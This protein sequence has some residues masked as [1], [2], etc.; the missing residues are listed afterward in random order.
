MQPGLKFFQLVTIVSTR[1]DTMADT[2]VT[3][4]ITAEDRQTWL[5]AAE[6]HRKNAERI[7]KEETRSRNQHLARLERR[8]RRG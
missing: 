2:Q 1:R 5:V 8:Q 7:D 3:V 6:M 4:R